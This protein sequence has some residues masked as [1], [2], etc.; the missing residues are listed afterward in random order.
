MYKLYTWYPWDF[1]RWVYRG[2]AKTKEKLFGGI[3]NKTKTTYKVVRDN[4]IEEYHE[5]P[6]S[7][8]RYGM[9]RPKPVAVGNPA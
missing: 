7:C 9:V 3:K 4:V 6:T 1:G 8:F 5:A 2:E